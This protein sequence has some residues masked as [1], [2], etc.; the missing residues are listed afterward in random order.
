V[1]AEAAKPDEQAKIR[2]AEQKATAAGE[3]KP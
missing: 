3:F 1:A 2:A